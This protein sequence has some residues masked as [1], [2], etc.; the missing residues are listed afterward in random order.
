M[1]MNIVISRES[2]IKKLSQYSF[3]EAF[4]IITFLKLYCTT[5]PSESSLVFIVEKLTSLLDKHD[6][7]SDF[8]TELRTIKKRME[9]MN[10]YTFLHNLNIHKAK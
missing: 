1:D 3:N 8:F 2:L 6:D 9:S 7:E 5:I 10:K 4:E